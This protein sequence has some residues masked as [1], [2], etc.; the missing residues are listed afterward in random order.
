MPQRLIKTNVAGS[1]AVGGALAA[2]R[3][4]LGIAAGFPVEA[5]ADAER[6]A[7]RWKGDPD[8][9]ARF[10]DRCDIP[11]VTVDPA[12]SLDLDQAF[13]IER[14]GDGYLLRYAVSA[15]GTF[16]EPGG[17]LDGE[18]HRRGQTFYGPDGSIPLHPE[19]LSHGAASLLPGEERPAYLWYHHLDAAGELTWTWVELAAVRSVAKL[20]YDQVQSALDG[21][22]PL[23]PEVKED[24]VALLAE[25]G[26]K[27]QILEASRGGISLALPAQAVEPDNGGYRLSYRTMT[28]VEEWNAQLSLVTGIAA[29]RLMGDANVGILRTMP[30]AERRDV[31]RLR[32]VARALG[33]TWPEGVSYPYFVRGIGARSSAGAAFLN[34][35]VSLFR[36]AGYRALPDGG[37]GENRGEARHRGETVLD[38][39][40]LATRYAHVTAPLRR[41]ADRYALETCRCI[42]TGDDLPAWVREGLGKLPE[43]MAA[44]AKIAGQYERGALDAVEALVLAGREGEA[45]DGVVV[46]VLRR[47]GKPAAG[48]DARGVGKV[49]IREP[50]V[51][52]T[53]VGDPLV[54]GERV[55]AVL[56]R[57]DVAT[58]TVE[59]RL[60]G[61]PGPSSD[62][63]AAPPSRKAPNAAGF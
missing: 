56:H 52:A 47:R 27:R 30:P 8:F 9:R 31:E 14:E 60:L 46:D 54:R 44:S 58:S 43:E 49:M 33:L 53:I 3:E 41:L 19:V 61:G 39:A 18:T 62:E 51:Q 63:G 24:Q 36:G 15:V 40:A 57:A 28:R 32:S 4:K 55:S 7:A 21:G 26:L 2:L 42:C 38:H 20:S 29:A 13:F 50:A 10:V 45:F 35:A 25:V 22:P 16:I 34:E 5:A 59:F 11:F 6:A 37:G 1:R 48:E 12:G 23:P 17:P